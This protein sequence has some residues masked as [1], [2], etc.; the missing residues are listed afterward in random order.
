MS[1]LRF[2]GFGDSIS[3]DMWICILMGELQAPECG[4]GSSCQCCFGWRLFLGAVLGQG[5][6]CMGHNDDTWTWS[7]PALPSTEDPGSLC[8]ELWNPSPLRRL[9]GRCPRVHPSQTGQSETWSKSS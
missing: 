3:R 5:M 7:C 4:E 8:T 1:V 9:A 6:E 2:G